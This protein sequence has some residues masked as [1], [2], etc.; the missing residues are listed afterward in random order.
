L[1]PAVARIDAA[2]LGNRMCHCYLAHRSV[3][4]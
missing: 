1:A 3:V 2:S 4:P